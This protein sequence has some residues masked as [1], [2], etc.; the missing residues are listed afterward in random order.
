MT[1]ICI[2]SGRQISALQAESFCRLSPLDRGLKTLQVQCQV[3]IQGSQPQ[4][5]AQQH[6]AML[7][8]AF[9]MTHAYEMYLE[10]DRRTSPDH[11]VQD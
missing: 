8:V 4:A 5:S 2:P 6:A 9:G 11:P 7:G 1:N 3:K 10:R